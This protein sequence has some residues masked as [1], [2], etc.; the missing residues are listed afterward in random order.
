[1]ILLN[2]P[3]VR[4]NPAMRGLRL[5]IDMQAAV[6][7]LI[8]GWRANGSTIG[9]GVGIAMGPA[10]VGPSVVKPVPTTRQSEAS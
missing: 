8:V 5:A 4:D 1:M 3:V 6:R 7:S 2:A 9:F 10:I